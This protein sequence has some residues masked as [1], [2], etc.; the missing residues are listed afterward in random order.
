MVN[1]DDWYNYLQFKARGYQF[2]SIL[3]M[4]SA[5][6]IVWF[7]GFLFGNKSNWLEIKKFIHIWEM[8]LPRDYPAKRL[9]F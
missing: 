1:D 2:P 5:V 4:F 9:Y 8:Q 6:C 3:T 7:Y